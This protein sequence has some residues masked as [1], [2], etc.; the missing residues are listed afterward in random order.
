MTTVDLSSKRLE[1]FD[2]LPASTDP[3][4]VSTL[5][6]STNLLTTLPA[7]VLQT[8]TA[9]TSIDV[10]DNKLI[11]F[12]DEISDCAELE[13]LVLYR[14]GLKTLPASI[15]KLGKLKVLNV[16]NNQLTKLPAEVGAMSTLEEMN[17]AAN[18]LLAVMAVDGWTSVKVLNLFDNR[19]V[20]LAS[21]APLTSLVELR[22]Y[23]NN[24]EVA[25]EMPAGSAIEILEMHN[26]RIASMPD[27]YFESTPKLV[28]LLLAKNGLAALPSSLASCKGLRFLQVGDN[29]LAELPSDGSGQLC[30]PALETLFL[31]R[32]PIGAL[33]AE[34]TT[35]ET[36][37][38]CN[39][40]GTALDDAHETV[41]LLLKQT[42]ARPGG[43]FWSVNGRRWQADDARAAAWVTNAKTNDKEGSF[44]KAEAAVEPEV[45]E[46]VAEEEYEE[47]YEEDEGP[48]RLSCDGAGCGH[49]ELIGD[50]AVW[51]TVD[52]D[53]CAKCKEALGEGTV[54]SWTTAAARI[55]SAVAAAAADGADDA[56]GGG[57]AVG[58]GAPAA[59]A[60]DMSPE[61][62]AKAAA[63]TRMQART[64]GRA[65]KQAVV[66]KQEE[67]GQ[68]A[69]AAT[70]MQ[71]RTRGRAATKKV[72]AKL[73][74]KQ[75]DGAAA[76][77]GGDLSGEQPEPPSSA[78]APPPPTTPTQPGGTEM[79][80]PGQPAKPAASPLPLTASG[81][82][83]VWRPDMSSPAPPAGSPSLLPPAPPTPNR[84]APP[85]PTAARAVSA[86]GQPPLVALNKRP[87][88]WAD[89][90]CCGL[91]GRGG[92]GEGGNAF[93][94]TL[95]GGLLQHYRT[96]LERAQSTRGRG[97]DSSTRRWPP[98]PAAPS[99]SSSS[100]PKV[101]D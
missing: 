16:F 94:S 87:S 86:T 29:Q 46:E 18:K 47:E 95:M 85:T 40:T 89:A 15:G 14:N 68:K 44:K 20:K 26:N 56:G 62:R 58:G 83:S 41:A 93:D 22:L 84:P 3:S 28:R 60:A 43:S 101:V 31:E 65:A 73:A 6:L 79:W 2:A 66:A 92:G 54:G 10:S 97:V 100:P 91:R 42:L 49:K 39:L 12:P 38:R 98:P 81:G 59:E 19:I 61:D 24:L 34:L 67:A 1:S 33:P 80:R 5:N 48:L 63:A 37:L 69:K 99:P 13:E 11:K 45:V 51:S 9:L 74:A 27:D 17:A 90:A 7:D 76:N 96:L 72:E 50:V 70:R 30:W 57:G 21:F 88:W 71:A 36:L 64:R 32:N 4:A 52:G 8:L 77:A 53:Y 75:A 25:P 78:A 35:S 82:A 55:T 23:N